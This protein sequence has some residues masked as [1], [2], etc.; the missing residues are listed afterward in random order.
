MEL[1]D[2]ARRLKARL[3]SKWRH[4]NWIPAWTSAEEQS[5]LVNYAAQDY[6]GVGEIVDLGCLLGATTLALAKGLQSSTSVSSKAKRIHAYD[7]FEWEEA[8]SGLPGGFS[9]AYKPG[10]NFCSEFESR[11]SQFAEYIRTYNGD[12]TG[13]GWHGGP[14]E[15]L[16]VD[17]SKS[18]ELCEFI[19]RVFH[20]RLLV[21]DSFIFEQDFK[22][23][24]TPWVHMLNY[25]LRSA[26]RP[27]SELAGTCSFVFKP[28]RPIDPAM[29][30]SAQEMKDVGKD[31][32]DEAYRYS[33]SL[34]R[35]GMAWERANVMAAKVMFYVHL[36][37]ITEAR[38]VLD[39]ALAEGFTIESDLKLCARLLEDAPIP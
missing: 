33:L 4:R 26:L 13:I 11:T 14:I 25:R 22:H 10:E 37:R 32:L 16:L 6:R 1:L 31:E 24:Y 36:A 20:P 35:D 12:L 17:A 34:V 39:A 19:G 29:I 38:E 7:R 8:F 23:C 28:I 15:F 21:D 18:W 5:Y 3:L 2:S 9:R 30:P 27:V